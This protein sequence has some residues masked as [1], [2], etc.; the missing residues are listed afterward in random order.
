MPN[1]PNVPGVPAL[2]SYSADAIILLVSDAIGSLDDFAGPQWGIFLDGEAVIDFDNFV[3]FDL[4][5]D[6]P[7]SDYPVEEGAFQ[8]YDKVQLPTDIRVR[9][10]A[11][12]SESN[13]Q[14][15]LASIDDVM[16]TVDLYDIVTPEQTYV[17]YNFTHRDLHRGATN[18]AG[19]ISVDLHLRE[20]RVTSTATFSNTQQ[21]PDASQEN[22][23]TVQPQEPPQS[24]QQNFAVNG[25][26]TVN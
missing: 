18:G 19:L 1:I 9:L 12:G 21:P 5:Q 11:G 10:S 3:S 24:V 25:N 16:N 15:F 4:R 2:A 14:N 20:I 23:G 8:S 26:W 7:V 17:S 22:I 13:R 6:L